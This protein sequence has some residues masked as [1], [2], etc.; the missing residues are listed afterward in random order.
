MTARPDP[1]ADRAAIAEVVRTFFAAFT[2]GPDSAARL[3]A[4]R[5]VFLP[6]ALIV[7]TCGLEPAVYDVDG[8]IAPR[9][10]L[11]SGGSLVDFSEWELHG[12]TEV[13]GDVAQHFCSY[14]K[15]GVQDGTPFTGRGMKTLQLVRTAAGWR[16]SAAAWDDE[17]Q[18]LTVEP[19]DA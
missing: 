18:G 1:V 2:S 19:G 17:R 11:L 10:A 6:E 5:D 16:I 8:F 4:L 14:E 7:R 15:A 3:E 12:R 9:Q 13:F